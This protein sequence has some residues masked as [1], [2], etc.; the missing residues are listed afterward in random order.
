MTNVAFF[1]RHSCKA[2]RSCG[3][4]GVLLPALDVRVLGGGLAGSGVVKHGGPL[5][6]QS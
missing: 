2:A 5:R 3:R 6:F 4:F 1:L